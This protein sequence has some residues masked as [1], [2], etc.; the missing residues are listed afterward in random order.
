MLPAGF[1]SQLQRPP[2]GCRTRDG[3][4]PLI[5]RM[6]LPHSLYS[7]WGMLASGTDKTAHI[8]GSNRLERAQDTLRC[9]MKRKQADI[10]CGSS[11]IQRND[12]DGTSINRGVID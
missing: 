3:V 9:R 2:L 12:E 8:L 1:N 4:Q 7:G 6:S 5:P 10:L 11:G